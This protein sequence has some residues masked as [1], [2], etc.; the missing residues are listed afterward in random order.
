MRAD[1]LRLLQLTDH[2]ERLLLLG[3]RRTAA[4]IGG[5]ATAATAVGCGARGSAGALGRASGAL[6]ALHRASAERS[7]RDANDAT[8]LDWQSLTEL[9]S[10]ALFGR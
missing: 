8:C 9:P 6:A 2:V 5:G 4:S 10:D 3:W 7:D 1:R